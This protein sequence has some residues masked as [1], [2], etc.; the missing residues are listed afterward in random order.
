MPTHATI[1][2]IV[3]MNPA[4]GESIHT[5]KSTPSIVARRLP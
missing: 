4:T 5:A 2:T 1:N 3:R